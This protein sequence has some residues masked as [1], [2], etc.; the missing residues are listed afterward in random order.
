MEKSA[1]QLLDEELK[2]AT[3]EAWSGGQLHI[4]GMLNAFIESDEN[5]GAVHAY[6]DPA[7]QALVSK[8]RK[9]KGR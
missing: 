1:K 9:L 2:K 7:Y 5:P 6:V 8:I 3:D 4:I